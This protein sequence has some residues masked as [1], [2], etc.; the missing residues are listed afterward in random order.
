MPKTDVKQ[1]V[2]DFIIRNRV[3]SVE[4]SDALGKEGVLSGIRP[5]NSGH[6]VAS[7]I[8]YVYATNESNWSVHEQI[9]H[10]SEEKIVFID[11]FDCANRA[12]I[13]DI[14][15]KYLFLYKRAKGIIINGF[16][17]DVHRLKKENYPIWCLGETPLGCTNTPVELSDTQASLIARRKET[18]EN[19][20]L[21]CDDSGC[22]VI[23]NHHIS[24]SLLDKLEAIELQEDIWYF[25]IDTLKLSTYETICQKI[26]L[27]QPELLPQ[28][29]QDKVI[30]L[31]ELI[32][33]QKKGRK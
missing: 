21:I 8:A 23:D 17:R 2:I 10:I 32:G 13:G 9:A 16:V 4:V 18:F 5:L 29:L 25:C 27:T 20:L 33:D 7:D 11:V 28:T 6:F 19:A 15:S 14:V 24:A 22:T 1:K 31:Q 30:K 12:I 26:Y 3:S